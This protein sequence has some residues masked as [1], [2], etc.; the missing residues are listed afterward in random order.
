MSGAIILFKRHEEKFSVFHERENNKFFRI[1]INFINNLKKTKMSRSV[2]Y[3][4]QA[5]ISF[6][7][8]LIGKE[9]GE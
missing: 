3:Q 5:G 1:L 4:L 6:Y 2:K 9:T 7:Y 8:F